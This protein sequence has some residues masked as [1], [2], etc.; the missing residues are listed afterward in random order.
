MKKNGFTLIELLA[1][2]VVLAIVM[3]L[4]TTTVLPYMS[5]A[6]KSAF[7]IEATNAVSGA[8]KAKDLKTLGK[9]TMP[10]GSCVKDQKMCFTISNL[11]DLGVYEADTDVFKGK[12]I[13]TNYNSINP[14]YTLYFSKNSEFVINGKKEKD[15]TKL[16][17]DLNVTLS[18]SEKEAF[19]TCSCE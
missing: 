19:S 13:I 12:I 16:P 4:A 2:I 1:V 14:T 8:E 17:D 11:V 7:L 5:E 18:E 15:Y 6:R 10:D 3:V 9:I